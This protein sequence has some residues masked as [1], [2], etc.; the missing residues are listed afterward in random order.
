MIPHWKRMPCLA[1]DVGVGD[2]TTLYLP[3]ASPNAMLSPLM[4]PKFPLSS[5]QGKGCWRATRSPFEIPTVGTVLG[6][7][8]QAQQGVRPT[9]TTL[10]QGGPP[11]KELAKARTGKPSNRMEAKTGNQNQVTKKEDLS[12]GGS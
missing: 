11:A 6:T 4:E 9:K 10:A 12:P 8:S 2:G 7:S 1:L 3:P 5:N